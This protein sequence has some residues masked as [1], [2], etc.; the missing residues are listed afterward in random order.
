MKFDRRTLLAGTV[1][2]LASAPRVASAAALTMPEQMLVPGGPF[3]PYGTPV[4]Q[5]APVQRILTPMDGFELVGTS[6]TPL[7]MLEGTIT[8]N[9]LHFERYHNGCPT[10]D[11]ASHR[12]IIHG[13]VRRT[14]SFSVEQ[15]HR[16]P[17]ISAPR[18]IECG[19]NS[20]FNTRPEAPQ[21]TAGQIHGL[22]S[23]AEWTGV[24]LSILLQEAEVD[25]SAHWVIAEGAD[26]AAMARSVP[27]DKCWD[28][29]IVALYQN[30]EP[31]R[32]E[33]GYPMRLLLPG[34]EG[35][36]QVKWLH[37]LKLVARPGET[38]DETSHYS[39]LLK[40]GTAKQYVLEVG[41]KSIILKP[42]FGRN[43]TGPGLYEISG[44]AWSGAGRVREV[45]V[46][47]DGGTTWQ[48]AALDGQAASKALTRF[49]LPWQWTGAPATL[50]SRATDDKGK[51]QPSRSAWIAPYASG[52][53]YHNN[54]MQAWHVGAEGKVANIYV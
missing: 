34:F 47:V 25:P 48:R 41:V 4:Q 18:F 35:N 49:R 12:L 36:M 9:G 13:L 37:R 8:P 6:R 22:V 3:T 16:Y 30:G 52:Q 28:D 11:A 43:M 27:L 31:L 51:V 15:L 2:G 54:S 10:I 29:A 17:M 23:C 40:D 38:R 24:P 50:L 33:Q 7:Q 32:A 1:A 45:D 21:M 53:S 42:S 19:G 39:E 5:V 44:L 20:A 14:L 26:A 46:S